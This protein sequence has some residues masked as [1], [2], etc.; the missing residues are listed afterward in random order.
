MYKNDKATLTEITLMVSLGLALGFIWY[1]IY[2][3]PNDMYK[4]QVIECMND[5]GDHSK[6]SYDICHHRLSQ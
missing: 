2:V 6:E 3:K 5:M 1:H 4:N